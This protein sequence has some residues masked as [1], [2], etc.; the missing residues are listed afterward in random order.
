MCA[1]YAGDTNI[2]V[3][4]VVRGFF[5]L[6]QTVMVLLYE[7]GVSPVQLRILLLLWANSFA[8]A[9]SVEANP[10][11]MMVVLSMAL[12]SVFD[13]L[14]GGMKENTKLRE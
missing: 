5:C 3:E 13:S 8:K 1:S 12:W 4:V 7:G 2:Q 9:C 6:I 10:L 11:E 14:D